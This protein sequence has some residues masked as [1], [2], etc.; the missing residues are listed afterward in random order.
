M[1]I[2]YYVLVWQEARASGF[3]DRRHIFEI[4]PGSRQFVLANYEVMV[5]FPNGTL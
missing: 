2:P 3:R 4:I 5:T 1:L